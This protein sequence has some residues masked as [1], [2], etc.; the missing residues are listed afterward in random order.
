[1]SNVVVVLGRK[2]NRSFVANTRSV[3]MRL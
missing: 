2:R 3:G 1:M